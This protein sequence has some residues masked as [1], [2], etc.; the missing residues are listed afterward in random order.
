MLLAAVNNLY[1]FSPPRPSSQRKNK[2]SQSATPHAAYF[3][4]F[5]TL[6]AANFY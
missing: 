3:A 1:L 5:L 4:A 6:R 2:A